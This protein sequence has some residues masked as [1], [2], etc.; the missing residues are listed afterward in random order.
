MNI[1]RFLDEWVAIYT[2]RDTLEDWINAISIMKD[3]PYFFKVK[4]GFFCIEHGMEFD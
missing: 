2:T 1:L 3:N 4:T